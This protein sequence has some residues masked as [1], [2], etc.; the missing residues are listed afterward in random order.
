[1]ANAGRYVFPLIVIVL[2]VYLA[3]QTLLPGKDS[4]RLAYSDLI[5]KVETSPDSIEN[6]VFVPRSQEIRISLAD[7]SM[8]ESHYPSDGAQLEFQ[9]LLESKSVHFDSKGS[10]DSS[11]WTILTYLLPFVLFFGFWIFLSRQMQ[12]RK[13]ERDGREP[14][15]E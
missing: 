1:V 6:V 9:H 12:T 3:S 5:A 15:L 7:G 10:G 8:L 11:W 2:L 4:N 13:R 14:G